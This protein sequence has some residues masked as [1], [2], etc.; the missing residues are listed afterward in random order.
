MVVL[1]EVIEVFK[2]EK[3]K[4]WGSDEYDTEEKISTIGYWGPNASD[5]YSCNAQLSYEYRL[6]LEVHCLMDFLVF[7]AVWNYLCMNV[8]E[9][10]N[11]IIVYEFLMWHRADNTELLK[12]QDLNLLLK[13]KQSHFLLEIDRRNE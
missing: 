2:E 9:F 3:M 11:C 13:Y 8:Y 4:S 6:I 1:I 10:L 12:Q 5:P 7:H